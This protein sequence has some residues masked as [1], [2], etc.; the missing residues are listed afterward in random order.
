NVEINMKDADEECELIIEEKKRKFSNVQN[1]EKGG[2]GVAMNGGVHV[3]PQHVHSMKEVNAAKGA[4]AV[5]VSDA[6]FLSAGPGIQACRE[7]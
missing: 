3:D 1:N 4:A 6:H 5:K 7:Q 2:S